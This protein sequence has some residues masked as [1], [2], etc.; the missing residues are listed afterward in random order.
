MCKNEPISGPCDDG[1]ACTTATECKNAAC[2]ATKLFDCDDKDICTA[3]TCSTVAGKA[4]CDNATQLDGFSCG[5]KLTCQSG[6]CVAGCSKNGD[7]K[8]GEVC[9]LGLCKPDCKPVAKLRLASVQSFTHLLDPGPHV[10][11]GCSLPLHKEHL[12]GYSPTDGKPTQMKRMNWTTLNA[13]GGFEAWPWLFGCAGSATGDWYAS[14]RKALN[15]KPGWVRRAGPFSSAAKW[16][17]KN[18]DDQYISAI[19]EHKGVLYVLRDTNS[20]NSP[21]KMAQLDPATGKKWTR[22]MS[23]VE[24][25]LPRDIGTKCTTAPN[26]TVLLRKDG[27]VIT[28]GYTAAGVWPTDYNT[29]KSVVDDKAFVYELTQ[30]KKLPVI[31]GKAAINPY[32]YYPL[33]YGANRSLVCRNNSW[34]ACAVSNDI[35]DDFNC[36][37]V[38]WTQSQCAA[39]LGGS[40]D[41]DMAEVFVAK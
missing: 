28:G 12:L 15:S 10:R 26:I 2:V 3:D 34:T 1:E 21:Y 5:D 39:F 7:C 27:A 13:K 16:E 33:A 14:G 11:S 31:A 40:A 38:G 29:A 8:G 36:A 18:P 30:K 32:S 22:C 25:D 20:S 35:D 23:R 4:K 37:A 6:K 17:Y 19:S 41:A 9:A 24:G